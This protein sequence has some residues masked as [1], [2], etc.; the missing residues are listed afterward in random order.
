MTN[1]TGDALADKV[2][3]RVLDYLEDKIRVRILI[4]GESPE[5]AVRAVMKA[6]VDE[7][8]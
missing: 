6:M 1:P 8:V 2:I 5:D 3:S 4:L 7:D